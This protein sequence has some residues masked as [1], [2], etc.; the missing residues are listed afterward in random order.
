MSSVFQIAHAD[1]LERTRRSNFLL[2]IFISII[3]AYVFCPPR[4]GGYVTLVF[5]DNYVG[6]FNSAWMATS[7]AISVSVFFSLIGFYVISNAIQID[8]ETKVSEIVASSSVHKTKYILGKFFSNFAI[9]SVIVF[10]T[11]MTAIVM[12]LIRG[13]DYYIDIWEYIAPFAFMLI[14]GMAIIATI[15]MVFEIIPLV[16]STFGNILFFFVWAF[17]IFSSFEPFQIGFGITISD[18]FG[19][20]IAIA[21]I[22]STLQ[23]K[24]PNY[25]GIFSN[26]LTTLNENAE[27][28][29]WQGVS[30]NLSLIAGRLLWILVAVLVVL[31]ASLFFSRFPRER[32]RKAEKSLSQ[33]KEGKPIPAFS[34]SAVNLTPVTKQFSLLAMLIVEMKVMLA[35]LRWWYLVAI[36]L[37]AFSLFLPFEIVKLV[38]WPVVW[39]WPLSVWSKIG[40]REKKYR[41]EEVIYSSPSI[42]TKWFLVTWL[43]GVAVTMLIGSG[44]AVRFMFEGEMT[45]LFVWL[46][47]AMFIPTLAF[48]CGVFIGN[49]KLFEVLYLSI[50]YMGPLNQLPLLHFLDTTTIVTTI[51]YLIITVI[52][53]FTAFVVKKKRL[54]L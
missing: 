4:N 11:M 25:N 9:L 48:S 35:G 33:M 21:D 12:Q 16:R 52:L 18:L 8:R 26:G 49:N 43:S 50:W 32:A 42:L 29:V 27:I 24:Y 10:I 1:F 37:V 17:L 7:V 15:A 31:V 34:F 23:A 47:G 6:L 41:T 46:I 53:L 5:G 44:V 28:F 51:I 2:T 3:L 19:Q 22:V 20:G 36:G 40:T 38:V 30:W 45:S 39:L 13:E 54:R 14:P